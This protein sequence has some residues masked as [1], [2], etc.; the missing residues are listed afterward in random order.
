MVLK[1]FDADPDSGSGIFFLFWL[2]YPAW[3]NSDPGTGKNIP[4][5]QHC[6]QGGNT[7]QT[8]TGSATMV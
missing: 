7:M 5:P 4:D 1:F 3:K 6:R 8:P 2:R